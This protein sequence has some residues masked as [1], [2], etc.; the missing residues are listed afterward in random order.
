MFLPRRQMLFHTE[1]SLLYMYYFSLYILGVDISIRDKNDDEI[2]WNI[3]FN[4]TY[5]VPAWMQINLPSRTLT[6]KRERVHIFKFNPHFIRST[7]P[8]YPL[9]FS[10]RNANV[11]PALVCLICDVLRDPLDSQNALLRPEPSS[12]LLKSPWRKLLTSHCLIIL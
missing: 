6:P 10:L 7:Q 2:T 12:P 1:G 9:Y 4:H 8:L 3:N 5:S 11:C